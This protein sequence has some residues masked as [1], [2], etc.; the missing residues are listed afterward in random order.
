MKGGVEG[1]KVTGRRR[2]MKGKEGWRGGG[3]RGTERRGGREEG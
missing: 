1:R 3:G 2:E